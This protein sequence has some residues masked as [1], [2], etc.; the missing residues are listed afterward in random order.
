V[1]ARQT[2]EVPQ[3]VVASEGIRAISSSLYLSPFN[4]D[5]KINAF[6]ILHFQFVTERIYSVNAEFEMSFGRMA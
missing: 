3:N 6:V 1:V 2:S 4:V 5:L